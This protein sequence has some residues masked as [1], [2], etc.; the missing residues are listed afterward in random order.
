MYCTAF[1]GWSIS[2]KIED[3]F[4]QHITLPGK[5]HIDPEGPDKTKQCG[6]TLSTRPQGLS[7]SV[8]PSLSVSLALVFSLFLSL[9]LSLALSLALSLSLSHF[10]SLFLALSLLLSLVVS[11]TSPLSLLYLSLSPSHTLKRGPVIDQFQLCLEQTNPFIH[12][13]GPI[14]AQ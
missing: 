4:P 14:P 1:S 5:M 6:E 11:I 13:S 12:V 8:T 3:Y 10:L 2:V 9:F 7:F